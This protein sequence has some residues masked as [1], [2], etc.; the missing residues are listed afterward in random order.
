MTAEDMAFTVN[1]ALD[2]RLAE[3]PGNWGSVV[4]PGFVNRVEAMD[5]YTVKLY[6]SAKP[7]LARWEYGL[8]Q[9][10]IV[11]KHYWAPIVEEARKAGTIEDQQ[12]ALLAHPAL[13]E[14]S[15][16]EMMFV[17]R[18]PGSLVELARNPNYYWA[19]STVKEYANGAYVEEKPGAF[20]FQDYGQ[21]SGDPV[22][23]LTRG[24][25][26]ESVIFNVYQNQTD[27]IVD[28]RSDVIDYVL[29]P[30]GIEP[31]LRQHLQSPNIKTFENAANQVRFL[32]FNMRRPPMDSKEFRQAVTILIER[33]FITMAISLQ[34]TALPMYSVVPEG[35]RLANRVWWNPDV[36]QIGRGLTREQRI[37]KVVDL[38]TSAGFSWDRPPRWDVSDRVVVPGQ[39]LKLPDGQPVPALE[40]LAP[41]EANNPLRATAAI[42]I[43]RWLNEAGLPV[44]ANLTDPN[45]IGQKVFGGNFDLYV[46]GIDLTAFP[47]YLV[48]LFHSTKGGFNLGGYANPEFDKVADAFLA[49]GELDAARDQAYAPQ[50]F[51]ADD[52]PV[53][54][55]FNLPIF[56]AY[57]SDT[58]Q[59]SFTN[60][61][62]GVQSAFQNINGPLSYS[63]IK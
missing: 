46:L 39:G 10:L 4:D 13:D 34:G 47:D 8:S 5:N 17:R 53:V 38:L 35:N 60:T 25:H 26:V 57:R 6:F 49:E 19:G 59:W 51:I 11:P 62:N 27:A 43:E 61:L 9:A 45:E 16:G 3:I 7:G 36:S 42:W 50:A 20:R 30:Q 24:P 54:T 12:E 40:L 63:R 28:L 31:S 41:S 21:P 22:V 18:E 55:L 52:V 2:L 1:T 23:T 32:G 48:T 44:I 33:E 14:P 56:E 15:A 58:V 29:S 37:D